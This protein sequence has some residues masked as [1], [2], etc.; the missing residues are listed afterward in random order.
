LSVCKLTKTV[1]TISRFLVGLDLLL[2]GRGLLLLGGLLRTTFALGG[3][4]LL[5][6]RCLLLGGCLL[7]L[8][9]GRSLLS[10]RLGGIGL[11]A[12]RLL[13]VVQL[14]ASGDRLGVLDG[15][16]VLVGSILFR[17]LVSGL[18]L[19]VGGGL[20]SSGG[21]RPTE[22]GGERSVLLDSLLLDGGPWMSSVQ[23]LAVRCMLAVLTHLLQRSSCITSLSGHDLVIVL[24]GVS[25]TE[26][27]QD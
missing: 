16:V 2:V 26:E 25:T 6:G 15:I 22:E 13:V 5:L 21:S 1:S 10:G 27:R 20:R 9:D 18:A 4:S 7:L 24:Q 3:R 19:L 23:V 12:V 11:V 17:D 8:L 14:G